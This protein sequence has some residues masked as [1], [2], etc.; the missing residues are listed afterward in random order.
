MPE[1]DSTPIGEPIDLSQGSISMTPPAEENF[2]A[3]SKQQSAYAVAIANRYIVYKSI[4][5]GTCPFLPDE[6]GRIDT[7]PAVNMVNASVYHGPNQ[8]ILKAHQ[9][10]HGFPTAEYVAENQLEKA[11]EFSGGLHGTMKEGARPVLL[12]VLEY[13]GDGRGQV[14]FIRLINKAE[15]AHPE[16]LENYALFKAAEREH[17]KQE[18]WKEREAAKLERAQQNGEPYEMKPYT[19]RKERKQGNTI[20]VDTSEPDKYLGYVLAGISQNR[21][22]KASLVIKQ[23]VSENIVSYLYQESPGRDGK[24]RSNPYRI[25]SLGNDASKACKDIIPALYKPKDRGQEITRP[26]PEPSM[27]M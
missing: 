18:K 27:G 20:T 1:R 26:A 9:K 7:T 8:L 22:C 21:P 19:P 10:E 2:S 15:A 25:Y 11:N 14:K 5:D 17:F 13:D 12:S 16:A 3:V 24:L 23:K 4:R 6:Q